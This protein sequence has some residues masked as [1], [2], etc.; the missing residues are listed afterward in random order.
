MCLF[1]ELDLVDDLILVSFERFHIFDSLSYIFHNFVI[2]LCNFIIEDLKAPM[3]FLILF[4]LFDDIFFEPVDQFIHMVLHTLE[5]S[6]DDCFGI[7]KGLVRGSLK[8]IDSLKYWVGL[9]CMKPLLLGPF[10]KFSQSDRTMVDVV[11][12][13][14]FRANKALLS[15]S[16][17]N[18]Y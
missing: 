13:F 16:R 8:V 1:V 12:I 3:V 9:T 2:V 15:A 11:L 6:N 17:V 10:N 18:A 5:S 7:I 4:Y 14:A